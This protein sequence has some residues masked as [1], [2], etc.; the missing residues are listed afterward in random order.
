MLKQ[1]E[2]LA[3]KKS[4]GRR[5]TDTVIEHFCMS[6]WILGGRRVFEIMYSN[7]KGVF[8]SPRTIV[9][10]LAAYN[11]PVREGIINVKVLVEYLATKKL[12][13]VVF[14]SA[15]ATAV[16]SKLKYHGKYN[17]VVG[18]SLPLGSNELPNS[19]L[20][21]VKTALDIHKLSA[22]YRKATTK[23]VIMAQPI[24]DG[25]APMRICS[26]ETDNRYTALDVA[27]RVHTIVEALREG[28]IRARG[29]GA[30]GDSRETK[31]QRQH[32]GLSRKTAVARLGPSQAHL[33]SL[34]NQADWFSAVCLPAD[35]LLMF[36][37]PTH[38]GAKQRV[39]LLR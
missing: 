14:L 32:I 4:K 6:V 28:G 1:A 35:G 10:K 36:Q 7:L 23:I 12:K 8:P 19:N 17:S 11:I 25:C 34:R 30:D 31:F 18:C 22:E 29:Y 39:G 33:D 37:D 27:N 20:S 3:G 9:T 26:F 24:S 13:P 2:R 38:L 5:Y 16:I 15:D 21:V